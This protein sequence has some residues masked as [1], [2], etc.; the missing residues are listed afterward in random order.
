[1]TKTSRDLLSYRDLAL[2]IGYTALGEGPVYIASQLDVSE[3]LVLESWKAIQATWRTKP[4]YQP[5][6]FRALPAMAS[7]AGRGSKDLTARL[8]G[9]PSAAA[10]ERSLAEPAPH[11]G[12]HHAKY[13]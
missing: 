5:R 6:R 10:A 2:L 1:M 3:E 11:R 4:K 9:D 8:M 13:D 7:Q 12:K